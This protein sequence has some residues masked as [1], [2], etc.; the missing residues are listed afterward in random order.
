MLASIGFAQDL[1]R[2]SISRARDASGPISRPYNLKIGPVAFSSSAGFGLEYLD[3]LNLSA[4]DRTGDLV[5]RP[6]LG[7][8]AVW[9]ATRLNSLEFRTTLGYTKYLSHPELDSQNLLV[10]PDSALKFNL[11]IGDVKIVFS[12]QFGFQ[13]DPIGDGSVSNVAALS[14]FT[15]TIGVNALWD[16]NDVIWSLGYNHYNLYTTGGASTT[17]TSLNNNASALDRSTDQFASAV[18]LKLAPTTGLGL[19]GT[20]SYTAYPKN[21]RGDST[22][23]TLGPFIDFQLTAYTRIILSGGYQLYS[24]QSGSAGQDPTQFGSPVGIPGI[25]GFG[26]QTPRSSESRRSDSD[27]SGYYFTIA[28]S[29][30]LNR[31]YSDRLVIGRE[32]QTGLLSDRT[33]STFV[34]YSSTFQLTRRLTLATSIGY[35]QSTQTSQFARSFGGATLPDFNRLSFGLNSGFQ[36]TRKLNVGIAYQYTSR[37]GDSALQEYTQNRLS[38]QFGYQF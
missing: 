34:N 21:S 29:H 28:V 2:P 14:R 1:P 24:S 32:F 13:D 5:L 12:E 30:R 16:L 22:V 17:D 10:S 15:N 19:E 33:I 31:Y 27:G 26:V 20:A 18:F 9:Q 3:N 38:L 36:I 35:E 4:T 25:S 23:Y 7:L 6:W 11:F 8:N 37:T